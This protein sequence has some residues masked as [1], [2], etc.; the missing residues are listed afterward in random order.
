GRARAGDH[1][2]RPQPE[3][4]GDRRGRRDR[5]PGALPRQA[6]LRRSAGFLLRRTLAAGRLRRA[7]REEPE[8]HEAHLTHPGAGRY[9]PRVMTMMP[10]A[11][12]AMPPSSI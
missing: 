12:S 1:F 11:I 5:R 7:A 9:R 6:P 8:A 2:A 4:E 3:P 10:S